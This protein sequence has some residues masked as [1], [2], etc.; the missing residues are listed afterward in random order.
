MYFVM[1]MAGE[2]LPQ[3]NCSSQMTLIHISQDY[4]LGFKLSSKNRC[5]SSNEKIASP[6]VTNFV[7]EKRVNEFYYRNKS[8]R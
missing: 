6:P 3:E 2:A 4:Q 7:S 1:I 8:E 5:E